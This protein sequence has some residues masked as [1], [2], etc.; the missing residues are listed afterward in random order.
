[1]MFD[2]RY[3]AQRH[4]YSDPGD[5]VHVIYSPEFDKQGIMS[6]KESGRENLYDFIQSHRDSVD[7]HKILQR[8]DAGDVSALSKVQ[9][10]FGD[11]SQFPKTYAEMLNYVIEGENTFNNLPLDV[12]E[13]FGFSFQRW[14][15]AAGSDDWL[16]KMGL[17]PT[18]ADV[19]NPPSDVSV[20]TSLKQQKEGDD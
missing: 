5:P 9:G 2:N 15:T 17:R 18:S 14:I 3:R 8:F 16:D 12:R 4:F 20:D 13:Q 1:M 11:F 10:Q 7:I 6:L 19:H